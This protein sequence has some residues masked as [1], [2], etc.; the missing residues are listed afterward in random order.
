MSE[1]SILKIIRAAFDA[2]DRICSSVTAACVVAAL[3]GPAILAQP[4]DVVK[5]TVAGVTFLVLT[6]IAGIVKVMLDSLITQAEANGG[7]A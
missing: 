5:A 4:D 6:L 7:D 2:I 1:T 3:L